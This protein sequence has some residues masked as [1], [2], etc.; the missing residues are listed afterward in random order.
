MDKGLEKQGIKSRQRVYDFLVDFITNNGYA[1]SVREICD[2]RILHTIHSSVKNQE[3][4][5]RRLLLYCLYGKKHIR[6]SMWKEKSM[7]Q[8]LRKR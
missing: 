8:S 3:R 2:G 5:Y 4:F 6:I 7:S 1:P